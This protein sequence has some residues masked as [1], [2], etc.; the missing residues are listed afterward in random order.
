MKSL[1]D[2]IVEPV[3]D[4]YSNTVNVGGKKLVVN[5]KIENWKFVNRVA[6]VIETPAA[7]YTPINKG[8][9]VI[10]HQNVFRTFYDMKGEKKK[11]RSWFKDNYYFCA[12]D[13]IYL[14]KNKSGYNSFND[15]CFVIPIRNREDL[16]LNKEEYL[17]GILKYGNKFLEELGI[18]PGD[19]VGYTPNSEWEFL[20]NN[21]R[22][23]CM[24]SNDI[25]IKYEHQ[26]NEKEYN[27]S[28]A[29]SC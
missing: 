26:G 10:I 23:Y 15:R 19:L 27:P 29:N 12:V 6:K 8:D 18:N 17:V 1:Y 24:K 5:T 7:F 11:S 2:F 14:Y 4:K 3:G 25:V 9:E 22:L 13:Q 16:T 28:W 21:K 20:V